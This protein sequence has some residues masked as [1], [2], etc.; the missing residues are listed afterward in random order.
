MGQDSTDNDSTHVESAEKDFP[1]HTT[2][3]MNTSPGGYCI[4]WSDAVPKNAQA[5]ELLCVREKEQKPWSIAVIRWI[6]NSKQQGTQLGIE[7]LAPR[8]KPC[9]VQ[10]LKKTGQH[11]VFLR[12]LLLPE[13]TSIGQASTLVTPRLPFKQGNKVFVRFNGTETKCVLSKIVSETGSF[14]QFVLATTDVL[15]SKTADLDKAVNRVDIEDEFD[16]L[17]PSL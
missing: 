2:L 5:G 11:S 8:A 15:D 17:W 13:L 9:A 14:S 10:Q 16:S 1:I 12:G 7:L 4:Q 6:R 3:L